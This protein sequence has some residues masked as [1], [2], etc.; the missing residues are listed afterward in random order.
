MVFSQFSALI[1]SKNFQSIKQKVSRWK[2]NQFERFR[3][4]LKF[5]I[6]NSVYI[7]IFPIGKVSFSRSGVDS[8]EYSSNKSKLTTYWKF[9]Y[10]IW[11]IFGTIWNS[12]KYSIKM[13]LFYKYCYWCPWRLHSVLIVL[14]YLNSLGIE[15]CY[16]TRYFLTTLYTL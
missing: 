7:P 9:F 8:S 13:K 3:S 12:E 10:T 11:F 1:S 4:E 16:F 6:K 2:N 14:T 5:G 15:F